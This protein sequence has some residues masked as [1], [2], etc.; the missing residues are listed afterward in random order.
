[1]NSN[2]ES[3][4]AS[5]I[6]FGKG[7]SAKHLIVGYNGKN[8]AGPGIVKLWNVEKRQQYIECK[9]MERSVSCI[10]ISSCGE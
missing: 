9:G 7:R 1:M 8:H 2:N 10:S 4:L 6:A 5:D 3:R